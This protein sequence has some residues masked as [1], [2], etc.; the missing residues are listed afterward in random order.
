VAARH[1]DAIYDYP[2]W[3][4]LSPR[5]GAVYDLFGTGRTAIKASLMRAPLGDGTK[6]LTLGINPVNS[7]VNSTTRAWTDT[8]GN[9]K[10]DC[11]LSNPSAQTVAADPMR[12]G[13]GAPSA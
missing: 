7:T 4:D 8:N 10:P 5:L 11:D 13:R 2:D 3:K 6:G 12:R 9:F 1:F